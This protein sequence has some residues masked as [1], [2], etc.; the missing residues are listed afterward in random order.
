MN[1]IDRIAYMENILR[2]G[3]AAA[4]VLSAAIERYEALLP[5][6]DELEK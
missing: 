4:S 2:E 1:Q 3:A 5:A 6:L